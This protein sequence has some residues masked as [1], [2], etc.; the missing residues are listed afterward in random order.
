MLEKLKLLAFAEKESCIEIRRHLHTHPELSFQEVETA[1]Y[2]YNMLTSFGLDDVSMIGETG[3]T[4]IIRGKEKGKAM[5]LRSDMDALPIQEYSSAIYSSQNQGVMHACGHDAHMAMLLTAAKILVGLK[6]EL[7]G[8]VSV[9]FQPAEE[10]I[11]GGAIRM[12]ACGI[13]KNP[14]ICSIIA[15]HVMPGLR[16]GKIGIKTGKFMAS[17]DEF[18]LIVHGKGGHAAMPETLVDPVLIAGHIIVA[19]Q[20]IVSRNANPTIPTILSIGKISGMG[21]ANVIPDEVIL[22]GTLRTMDTEWREIALQR[23]QKLVTSLAESMGGTCI[24]KLKRGY[25][26][27]QN[28]NKLTARIKEFIAEYVGDE[29]VIN[30]DIWMAADDFAHYSHLVPSTYYLL[31]TQSEAPEIN[32]KLHT[33]TFDI[34]E[35]SLEIGVGLMAWLTYRELMT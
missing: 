13:L 28:D 1:A 22:E 33:P 27:L 2:I 5:L 34:D 17:S 32:T 9:L 16:V 24:V 4:G 15:Q 30:A 31:G 21:A 18:I 6:N 12:I 3:V 29:N 8:S 26:Y 35:N 11:P 19:L 23:L 10:R 25:P 20:Q 7:H 14:T